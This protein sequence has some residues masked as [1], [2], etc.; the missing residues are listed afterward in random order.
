MSQKL[1][2]DLQFRADVDSA[3]KQIQSLQTTINKAISSSI[4]GSNLGLTPQLEQARMSAM[5]LK[6]ALD[7]ATNVD[8]GKLNLN[9]FSQQM[10]VSGLS[11]QKLAK[12]MRA[13]GPEGVK[14]F[15]QMTDALMSAETKV[16]SISNSMQRMV[17]TFANTIRYQVSAGAIQAVTNSIN[18]AITYAKQLDKSLTDIRIVTGKSAGE[19]KNFAVQANNAAKS[20]SVSTNEYLKASHIYFQQGLDT[21]EA[22]KRAESTIKLA[23]A[24]GESM[25]EVSN[26]MTAIWNNFDNGTKSLE[27]YGDVLAKL[28]AETASSADE[29]AQGLEKFAAVADTVGL[30]YEYAASALATVTAET[31]QS[32]DVV[33]TAFKTLFARMEGLKL[34]ETLDD[35]T[36]LNQYSLALEAVGVDIKDVNGEMKNMDLI[37]DETALKW[38]TLSKDQQIAL[39]QSVAGV[40]QYTQFIALMDNYDVMQNNLESTR[41]ASGALEEMQGV[42]EESIEGLKEKFGAAKEGLISSLM[43]ESSIKN[44]Y[45]AMNGIMGFAGKLTKAFGGLQGILLM[46]AS[47]LTKMYQPKIATMFTNMAVSAN[48]VK[49]HMQNVATRTANIFRSRDNKK[50]LRATTGEQTRKDALE[51]NRKFE[52]SQ[53]GGISSVQITDKIYEIKR[54]LL[55]EEKT[56]TQQQKDQLNWQVKIL[57]TT[58]DTLAAEEARIEALREANV[59]KADALNEGTSEEDIA[60]KK[61]NINNIDAQLQ[62]MGSLNG[63]NAVNEL[64]QLQRLAR[65][66]KIDISNMGFEDAIGDAQRFADGAIENFSEVQKK[67]DIVK[68]KISTANAYQKAMLAGDS[69]QI[70]SKQL[71]NR[72]ETL[73]AMQS[74][75]DTALN[76]AK[77]LQISNL[78]NDPE[79]RAKAAQ[80]MQSSLTDLEK[81][82]N[83]LGLNIKD[84]GFDDAKQDVDNFADNADIQIEELIQK[85]Q[86]LKNELQTAT[87]NDIAQ[88]V[89]NTAIDAVTGKEGTGQ[90]LS[91][92]SSMND[93]KSGAAITK[94]KDSGVIDNKKA[95]SLNKSLQKATRAQNDYNKAKAKAENLQ[96]TGN[97]LS[98]KQKNALA[99]LEKQMKDS[100]KAY[101]DEIGAIKDGITS[102]SEYNGVISKRGDAMKETMEDS[103]DLGKS[104]EDLNH[105]TLSAKD[106]A[107]AF[108]QGIANNANKLQ[109]FGQNASKV[110]SSTMSL[111]SGFNMIKNGVTSLSQALGEGSKNWDDYLSAAMSLI[112]GLMQV[113]PSIISITASVYKGV[114]ALA[115]SKI[116]SKAEADQRVK[117]SGK[118]VAANIT[119]G[120]SEVA[121]NVAKGYAFWPVAIAGAAALAL[122]GAT[123]VLPALQG[124]KEAKTE[125]KREEIEKGGE[126]VSASQEVSKNFTSLTEQVDTFKNLRESGESTVNVLKEM[127]GTV[128]SIGGEID[129][130]LEKDFNKINGWEF[131]G[132][133]GPRLKVAQDELERG[134]ITIEEYEAIVKEEQ[135]RLKQ[136]EINTSVNT[137]KQA[138]Q[139]AAQT[140]KQEDRDKAKESQ[141]TLIAQVNSALTSDENSLADAVNKF[142]AGEPYDTA[143]A[144]QEAWAMAAIKSILGPNFNLSDLQDQEAAKISLLNSAPIRVSRVINGLKQ[145][146]KHGAIS[147]KYGEEKAAEVKAWM[148]DTGSYK[149]AYLN[150]I[151]L[152]KPQKTW[153]SQIDEAIEKENYAGQKLKAEDKYKISGDAFEGYTEAIIANNEALKDNEDLAGAVAIQ[154]V[155]IATGL[156]PLIEKF[157]DYSEILKQGADALKKGEKASLAYYKVLDELSLLMKDT[158]GFEISDNFVEKNLHLLEQVSIGSAEA[159]DELRGKLAKEFIITYKYQEVE[160]GEGLSIEEQK[161]LFES[162]A[163]D[164]KLDPNVDLSPYYNALNTMLKYGQIKVEE[165][166]TFF[167]ASGKAF[168]LSNFIEDK[169]GKQ[170]KGFGDKT[171]ITEGPDSE[172]L[173]GAM[174]GNP[175][176]HKKLEDEI[177]RYHELKEAL[178]DIS[179]ELSHISKEKNRAFGPDKISLIKKE[180]DVLEKDLKTHNEYVEE[181]RQ[182]VG[183][184]W[185]VLSKYGASRDEKGRITNYEELYTTQLNELNRIYDT[186]NKT[187]IEKAD[188]A[189]AQFKKDFEQ[190]E[191]TLN[192]FEKAQYDAV[193]KS[194]AIYDNH[195]EEVSEILNN[196]LEFVEDEMTMLNHQLE[197]LDDP[198]QD[199]AEAMS[200]L[201]KQTEL[202]GRKIQAYENAIKKTLTVSGLTDEQINDLLAGNYENIEKLTEGQVESL[203]EYRD[204]L[205]EINNELSTMGDQVHSKMID[206]IESMN[207]EMDKQGEIIERNNS[208]LSHYRNVIDLVGKDSLGISDEMMRELSQAEVAGAIN[209]IEVSKAALEANKQALADAQAEYNRI[210]NELSEEDKKRWNETIESLQDKVA[211]GEQE[212]AESFEN[213]L[214]V[215]ADAFDRAVEDATQTL[216]DAMAGL[217]GSADKM[218]RAFDQQKEI[219]SRYLADYQKIYELSKLNR[220]IENSIDITDSVRGK[221]VL[222]DLQEEILA[223]QESG[224]EMTQ[225]EMDELRARY[226]LRVA[227]IALEEAQNAKSQVRMRRDSEGN[228]SYVYT[229]DDQSVDQARQNYEDKLYAYQKLNQEYIESTEEGL[230]NIVDEMAEAIEQLDKTKYASEEEYLAAV[231]EIRQYYADKY[232]YL[233][234]EMDTVLANSAH[235]YENDWKAYSE[236]TGYKMSLDEDWRDQ[237]DETIYAQITG[238]KNTDEA[239]FAFNENSQD[240][241]LA[242]GKAF[243]DWKA[244]TESA[245]DK[246]GISMDNFAGVVKENTKNIKKD[247]ETA[248]GSASDMSQAHQDAFKKIVSEA[249]TWSQT[250]SLKISGWITSNTNLANSINGILTS[251]QGIID[252]SPTIIKTF[253]AIERAA[254]AANNATSNFD[255]GEKETSGQ[256]YGTYYINGELK[257]TSAGYATEEEAR[258]AASIEQGNIAERIREQQRYEISTGARAATT[259]KDGKTVSNVQS[260]A[261]IIGNKGGSPLGDVVT[262][263]AAPKYKTGTAIGIN[264]YNGD[265]VTWTFTNAQ[266]ESIGSR[267][268]TKDTKISNV[269][270]SDGKI[271][272]TYN[273]KESLTTTAS[274][275]NRLIRESGAWVDPQN[276]G[277]IEVGDIVSTKGSSDG[278]DAAKPFMKQFTVDKDGKIIE[279]NML[280]K[281]D[282]R[283][284]VPNLPVKKIDGD[285]AYTGMV[286]FGTIGP[287]YKTDDNFTTFTNIDGKGQNVTI[288]YLKSWA[289]MNS[290]G[291]EHFYQMW[292]PIDKLTDSFDTGGYTGSWGSSG[293]LAMLHQKEIVLNAHDTENFLAAVNIV[294]DIASA[295]DLRAAA[296]EHQLS[297]MAYAYSAGGAPQ[298]LQQDVTIHAEFPN[299]RERSEIEAAFDNLINR[300][301]QFANRKNK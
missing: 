262:E 266:G 92:A 166:Q 93:K 232:A 12:D 57:E 128:K 100:S 183:K 288:D 170:I 204:S 241:L 80:Q 13:L 134:L 140:G 172:S 77:N 245:F 269:K 191:T 39:A 300:A 157:A 246:A 144:A 202:A 17:S 169:D 219:S 254:T 287:A 46:A 234:T 198:I 59:E 282:Y 179:D 208:L 238:Y 154:T 258:N 8:T 55:Q 4:Q 81:R 108:T 283:Y 42:Y 217:A 257:R 36:T 84:L 137:Y 15:G 94:L 7:K 279:G 111:V 85:I 290:S 145:L 107:D 214:Q 52:A 249:G 224:V 83:T 256:Y 229:A 120:T 117:D 227:E 156:N 186:G 125:T 71:Q 155:Q 272:F 215:A 192:E 206:A 143:E 23:H 131:L 139:V 113:L 45:K 11:M 102:T 212:L 223:M 21:A 190:Y 133:I 124:A 101:Q 151:D 233:I 72:G 297:S 9:K 213:A 153:D 277:K 260:K 188:E 203:R 285:K 132:N 162:I 41:E 173:L 135:N 146:E 3:K 163:N 158:F 244:A 264:G 242:L 185:D 250:Y 127:A 194:N 147:N 110:L 251:Y 53:S 30:S 267:Y 265:V 2:V 252:K 38:Q 63:D 167:A 116:A 222:R 58:R 168:T 286:A 66:S 97:K 90:A 149:Y 268:F 231:N 239:L 16:F 247:N 160:N 230:V 47:A 228:F 112:P 44:F 105:K 189:Y 211:E 271:T 276:N 274:N 31:R 255:E 161:L 301:S 152:S 278:K 175:K 25:E 296:Y 106:A 209:A 34:G 171:E 216:K 6:S 275:F 197:N 56:L 174:M 259:V 65:E 54:K 159:L 193:D 237:F 104:Q 225:Y 298:M 24:T 199:A 181:L 201:G 118:K 165:L 68:E 220:Q 138:A 96:K 79:Q 5:Q 22:M 184:D 243:T 226:D 182:D 178:A 195:L 86:K 26:W 281:S 218:S 98:D 294:R 76:T 280:E 210:Q 37:L 109:S 293:R 273:G 284:G 205:L 78:A 240:Y 10:K 235:F 60:K 50:E 263:D 196:E 1:Y 61:E 32:A 114:A 295:I 88:T 291:V 261:E 121:K 136:A 176:E 115:A 299:V 122:V 177:E 221:R 82:A 51:E 148:S 236:K 62:K 99:K 129:K 27:Y 69:V 91:D 292:F 187:L 29:I 126:V 142:V 119:E 141:G 130:L 14:A 49:I 270:E 87:T 164:I 19:M 40:R 67:I 33:G 28:G 180:R 289:A 64:M 74:N 20:L 73:G 18:Q 248:A 123:V 150:E 200:N 207:E 95:E 35:G 103:I 43:D 253:E 75:V 89:E 70:N 48:D